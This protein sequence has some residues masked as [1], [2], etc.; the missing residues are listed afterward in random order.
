MESYS[1]LDKDISPETLTL[2]DE[3]VLVLDEQ[4]WYSGKTP[5]TNVTLRAL[6]EQNGNALAGLASEPQ[7]M[8]KLFYFRMLS[9]SGSEMLYVYDNNSSPGGNFSVSAG[10]VV[11]GLGNL[12]F[13][14]FGIDGWFM[15]RV[16]TK[17]VSNLED[18]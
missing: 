15:S 4:I 7:V 16:T 13:N 11:C 12:C 18:K 14:P 5:V 17:L 10:E 2:I 3:Q 9:E 8:H 6:G 1:L